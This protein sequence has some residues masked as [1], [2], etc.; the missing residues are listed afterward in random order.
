[1]L[2]LSLD[3][4]ELSNNIKIQELH[5][6]HLPEQKVMDNDLA[7]ATDDCLKT[8]LSSDELFIILMHELRDFTA[9]DIVV[10]LNNQYNMQQVYR[11]IKLAAKKMKNCI[12]LKGWKVTDLNL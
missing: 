8:A 9:N 7:K 6:N 2:L 10:K 3:N 11:M 5:S 12:E 4:P 1:M